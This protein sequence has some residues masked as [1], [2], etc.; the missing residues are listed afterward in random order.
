[1][2]RELPVRFLLAVFLLLALILQLPAQESPKKPA[3]RSD[4]QLNINGSLLK[5]TFFFTPSSYDTIFQSGPDPILV[6]KYSEKDLI[7][8]IFEAVFDGGIS[9]YDPNYWGT[10]PQLLERKSHE[11]FDTMQILSYLSAG[12]DTSYMIENDGSMKEVP[13]YKEISYD[14][15]GGLFFYESWWLDS[16]SR[17]LRVTVIFRLPRISLLGNY[18]ARCG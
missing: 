9:V 3:R 14:E 13:E 5:T 4:N 15:V 11:K 12:W 18:E 17:C 8:I 1:M 10:L 2:N 6:A 7:P 16:K